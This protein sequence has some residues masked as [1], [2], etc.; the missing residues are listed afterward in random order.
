MDSECVAF[1]QWAL[2]RLGMRWAGFRKVRGQVCKRIARRLAE[3]GLADLCAYRHRLEAD[4]AEWRA[5]ESL[6]RVTISRFHRDRGVFEL[7][8][9]RVLPALAAT[10]PP[11]A[12]VDAAAP[13]T[14]VRCWSAGCASGEEPYTLALA[15]R[16]E[17]QERF[18]GA[19]LS[20]VATDADD[21]LLARA[22]SARYPPSALKELPRPWVEAA[23]TRDDG[24]LRLRPAFRRD[25]RF[26]RQDIRDRMPDGP[27]HLV[28]CRNLVF[29]YFEAGVQAG[30][31]DRMLDRLAPDGFLVLGSH[32]V[33]PP[34]HWP[35]ERIAAGAPVFRR[36]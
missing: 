29:T 9:A 16:L 30:L 24:E 20:V 6:C 36:R 31:L 32:E 8:R 7:I 21:T 27:F 18:P 33:L 19:A 10:E 15:W 13:R 22:R 1:L 4:P 23:F 25:V 2:P 28:L 5:L 34:G 11:R 17:V 3:L 12:G 26:R 14:I 35:L